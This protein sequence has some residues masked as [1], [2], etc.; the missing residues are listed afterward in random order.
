VTVS[1]ASVIGPEG[2]S[3]GFSLA[4]AADSEFEPDD[5]ASDPVDLIDLIDLTDPHP[6]RDVAAA[7][8]KPLRRICRRLRQNGILTGL[9][10]AVLFGVSGIDLYLLRARQSKYLRDRPAV[11]IGSAEAYTALRIGHYSC[12]E[13]IRIV[14]IL[15]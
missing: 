1:E 10:T 6:F 13:R 8:A 12:H 15:R 3:C 4:E 2:T 7:S 14:G 11:F 9:R 5:D